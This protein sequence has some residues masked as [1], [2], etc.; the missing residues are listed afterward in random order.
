MGCIMMPCIELYRAETELDSPD[1]EWSSR[2]LVHDFKNMVNVALSQTSLALRKLPPDHPAFANA[3][4]ALR[5]MQRVTELTHH[6]D[7]QRLPEDNAPQ[8]AMASEEPPQDEPIAAAPEPLMVN[9]LIRENVDLLD[10]YFSEWVEVDLDCCESSF[11]I[12]GDRG[13]IQ[14]AFLNLLINAAEAIG[15]NSGHVA[16]RTHNRVLAHNETKHFLSD[17]ELPRGVYVAL[18]I[19]DDGPGIPPELM[20]RILTPYFTTKPNG[21]GVGLTSALQIIKRHGGG[22]SI[23]SDV[24]QGTTIEVVLPAACPPDAEF[25]IQMPLEE[26][27]SS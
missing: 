7:E 19:T 3:E 20:S 21:Q 5:A 8:A 6:L 25:V 27:W 24:G 4:K 2:N 9:Q 16:I 11:Q 17:G 1:E 13:Q 10:A 23:H 12:E 18:E 22:M 14:Q 26:A 15:K